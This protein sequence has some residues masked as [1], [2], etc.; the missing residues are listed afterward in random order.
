MKGIIL[1]Y[2]TEKGSGAISGDDDVR[3]KFTT[4]D[5][6][7][8]ESPVVGA[9]VDFEVNDGKA[10]DIYPLTGASSS[11]AAS[12]APTASE[13]PGK[14]SKVVAGLL[15]IFLNGLGIHKFYL[16]H[17]G[18]GLI[19]LL[20]VIFGGLLLWIPTIIVSIIGFVEGIL[21]LVKSDEEFERVYVQ[22]GKAWF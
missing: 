10:K 18:V 20:S 12:E 14:K 22:E 1:G 7:G 17:S 21:Y 3:Y 19:M 4:D 9:T 6:M 13:A 8:Q 16:G 11:S 2:Y 15:G 5:F